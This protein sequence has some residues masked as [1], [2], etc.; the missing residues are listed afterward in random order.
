MKRL[1][2]IVIFL[3][4]S[5]LSVYGVQLTQ[6]ENGKKKRGVFAQLP[7]F[8]KSHNLNQ[9]ERNHD[10][11]QKV[12]FGINIRFVSENEAYEHGTL[13][14][15]TQNGHTLC[16]DIKYLE[17]TYLLEETDESNTQC[18]NRLK[19]V[20]NPLVL[21][22][23]LYPE[24]VGSKILYGFAAEVSKNYHYKQLKNKITMEEFKKNLG[25][26]TANCLTFLLY[27]ADYLDKT[28][29]RRNEVENEI[30]QKANAF[31]VMLANQSKKTNTK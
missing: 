11:I 18:T 14:G 28:K 5:L 22:K 15:Q 29:Q 30:L 2:I 4:N 24:M 25:P 8:V 21:D 1:L 9:Y 19:Y 3:I 31:Q 23:A 13:I 10:K 7:K 20:K 17:Y 26:K 12:Y 6:M 27:V 16:Y